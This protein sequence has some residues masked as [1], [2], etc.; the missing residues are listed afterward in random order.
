M[1]LFHAARRIDMKGSII[2]TDSSDI[3]PVMTMSERRKTLTFIIM[4]V[5]DTIPINVDDDPAVCVETV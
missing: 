4:V 2:P 3:I 5:T 1:I